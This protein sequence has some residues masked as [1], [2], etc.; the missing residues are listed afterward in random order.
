[1]TVVRLL[2]PPR[3]SGV[4][5]VRGRKPWA[6][7][8]LLLCSTGPVPRCRAVELLFPDTDDPAAALRWTLS[9]ARRATGGAVRIGGD[10]LRAEPAD[11]VAV[12]VLDVLAGRPPDRWPVVEATLPLLEG[13]EPDVPEYAAWLHGR[14]LELARS[15]L[16]MQ[17]ARRDLPCAPAGLG[18]V[19]ELVRVAEEVLADALTLA[20]ALDDARRVPLTTRGVAAARARLGDPG[21]AAETL[22]R[23]CATLVADTDVCC[24][25]EL[26]P[27]DARCAVIADHAPGTTAG[28]HPPAARYGSSTSSASPAGRNPARR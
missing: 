19:R 12:D 27:R 24:P 26:H 6:L 20:D 22:R 1:M 18:A 16:R 11:G 13:A 23:A 17:Q 3:A 25:I 15:G 7:L 14:R 28:S 5:A 4:P 10:P 2:G 8:A 21:G 9:R